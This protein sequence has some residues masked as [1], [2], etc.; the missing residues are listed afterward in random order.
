MPGIP[1]GV[2]T[3][4]PWGGV[5]GMVGCTMVGVPGM[6][7]KHIQ[8]GTPS[9]LHREAYTPREAPESSL[10][11]LIRLG[12]SREPLLTLITRLGDSREPL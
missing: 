5:P 7:G 8:Q 1:Q 10:S 3:G 6:V 2:P 4:V 9:R 12:G 11:T